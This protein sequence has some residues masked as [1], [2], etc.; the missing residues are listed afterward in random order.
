[1]KLDPAEV[2]EN[3]ERYKARLKVYLDH[4]YDQSAGREFIINKTGSLKEPVLEIGT[5][6]GHLMTLLA[7]KV[8]K[9][10]T[11]DVSD[12]EQ[13]IAA[14]NAAAEGV[15]DR[16]EF[17]VQ[18]AARLDYPDRSFNL[19]ISVNAFHHFEQPFAVLKEMVRVCREKLVIA[20]FNRDGFSIIRGI[21]REEGRE[22]EER[23][24]DFGIVGAYLKEHGFSVKRYEGNCQ[25]IYVAKINKK[26]G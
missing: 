9:L 4:G 7:K 2:R 21:H 15:L 1:M 16:I 8:K 19:V 26:R 17:V 10:V 24:G 5:G 6:K 11:V 25:E 18:D 23:G 14:L 22:H 13:K 20:D 3:Q 12:E